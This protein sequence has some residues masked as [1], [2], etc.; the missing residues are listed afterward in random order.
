MA[1]IQKQERSNLEHLAAGKGF[2][3][4]AKY[5]TS[6]YPSSQE[7]RKIKLSMRSRTPLETMNLVQQMSR[8]IF[9]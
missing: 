2:S 1:L 4:S 8:T 9:Q 7:L 5:Q 6:S 3:M